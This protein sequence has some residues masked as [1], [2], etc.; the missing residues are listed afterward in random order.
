LNNL[1]IRQ[2]ILGDENGI[3]NLILPIQV[4]EFSIPITIDQQPDLQQIKE[5]YQKGNGNFWIAIHDD[6]IIGT[7]A[8]I[9]IGNQQVALRKMFVMENYRGKEWNIAQQL[10][11][12]VFAWCAEKK[13]TD[14]YLGTIDA[15]KA[16]QRFYERNKFENLEAEELPANFPR[17]GVD[18]IFYHLQFK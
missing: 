14:I 1:T 4:Q 3:I 12:V 16:A 5:V 10:L 8:L 6:V 11:E 15:F 7:I 9:D 13:V 2:F 18:N 17:M